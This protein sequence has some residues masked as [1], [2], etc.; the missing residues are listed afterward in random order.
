ME[1]TKV[2]IGEVK[3]LAGL[4]SLEFSEEELNS[5]IPEFENM[6]E[7]VDQVKNCDVSDVEVKYTSH[8]LADLREDCAKDSLPQEEIL[9]NSPKTKKGSFCVPKMLD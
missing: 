9:L 6:L 8:K 7:L 5:F 2:T 1:K 3:R 4:S